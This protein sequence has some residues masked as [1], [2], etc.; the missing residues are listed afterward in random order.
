ML[1]EELR[2][3]YRK[4]KSIVHLRERIEVIEARVMSITQR[5]SQ[6]PKGSAHNSNMLER[7]ID[8]KTKLSKMVDDLEE[9]LQMADV[10]ISD[11]KDP[12]LQTVLFYK[13]RDMLS[14]E[15]VARKMGDGY[16]VDAL[17]KMVYRF[18]ENE[19]RGSQSSPR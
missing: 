19:E 14:W 7:Y 18:F 17:K 2:S 3:I 13:Y 11:I 10:F 16:S 15:D 1:R 6:M 8:L 12:L 4:G 9:E 5:L